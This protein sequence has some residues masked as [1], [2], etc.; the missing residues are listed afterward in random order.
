[1]DTNYFN[2]INERS[3]GWTHQFKI[4][5]GDLSAAATTKTISL[6]TLESGDLVRDAAFYLPTAFV[7]AAV[8]NLTVDVGHNAAA[9]A[10]DADSILDAYEICGA[11]TEVLA[12]DANGAAF[13]TLRTGY[14]A[15]EA[16]TIEALFTATGANTSVLTAG[17]VWIYLNVSKLARLG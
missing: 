16:V 4:P 1:M 8:T 3:S 5:F 10:D 7:G 17:E 12:G 6:L 9:G 15:V 13:A 11:A 14:A 2:S